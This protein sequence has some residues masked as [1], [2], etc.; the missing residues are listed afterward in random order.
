MAFVCVC[1]L[2]DIFFNERHATTPC[3]LYRKT[4]LFLT[5]Q[6]TLDFQWAISPVTLSLSLTSYSS[7]KNT[8]I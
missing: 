4:T 7:L 5:I 1:R 2:V 6:H 3:L 8:C